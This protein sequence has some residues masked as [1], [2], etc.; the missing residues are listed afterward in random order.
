V[1][2]ATHI[3]CLAIT[4]FIPLIGYGLCQIHY[5]LCTISYALSAY[6]FLS[7]FFIRTS[8]TIHTYVWCNAW[9]SKV[10]RRADFIVMVVMQANEHGQTSLPST[11]LPVC[12]VGVSN[13]VDMPF[14]SLPVSLVT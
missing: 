12:T 4:S 3:S 7:A 9:G 6:I 11:H 5:K 14:L 13:F 1:K 8:I 2:D 10:G